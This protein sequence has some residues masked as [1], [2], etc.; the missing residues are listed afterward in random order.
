MLA[1]F[2]K[3]KMTANELEKLRLSILDE[4]EQR[5]GMAFSIIVLAVLASALW[6]FFNLRDQLSL[7]FFCMGMMMLAMG[8]STFKAATK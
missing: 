1:K 3:I 6:L 5:K 4:A 2:R 7:I 8:S